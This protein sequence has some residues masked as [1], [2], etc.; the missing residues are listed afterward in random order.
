MKTLQ[1]IRSLTTQSQRELIEK[2]RIRNINRAKRLVEEQRRER[3][4]RRKDIQEF[5]L[6]CEEIIE[7][8]AKKGKRKAK[9]RLIYG[10]HCY[11]SEI[12]AV[13]KKLSAFNPSVF[14]RETNQGSY[15][16]SV[17]SEIRFNW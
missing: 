7:S 16:N 6:L 5:V 4:E 9:I 12:N 11:K 15:N 8:A 1:E 10:V 13:R 14:S 17:E 2:R 3:I